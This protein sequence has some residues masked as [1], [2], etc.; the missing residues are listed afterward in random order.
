MSTA[1]PPD[2]E[3][4]ECALS[5]IECEESFAEFVKQAWPIIEPGTQLKWGWAM[6]AICSHLEAV[7]DGRI[8]RLLMNVPPGT[9]KSTLVGVMWP[10]WEWTQNPN[11]RYISTAHKADLAT[12]DNMKCR[13]L[14]QSEWYQARWPIVLVSD[15]NAKTKFENDSTGFRESMAFTSMTG[16]RG[17]RVILDDPLSADD[18]N[19]EAALLSAEL[20]FTETLPTRVNN[21]KSAIVVIMQRLHDKDTSGLILDRKL[22]YVHLRLPMR[23]EADNICE[24]EIGFKDPRTEEGE[25]LFEER[26]SEKQV[27]DLEKTMGSYA[28]AGQLQQRPTPRSGGLFNREWFQPL[29]ELPLGCQFVR[30]WDLAASTKKDSPYTAGVKIGKAPDGRLIIADCVRDKMTA[31]GVR[32]VIKATTIS[33]KCRVSIPQ[34]PG[35]AGKAQKV[36]FAE[37][38]EGFDCRFSPESGDKVTRALP[39]SAQ[40][41]AGNVY[42]LEGEWNKDFIDECAMFPNGKYKDQVDALSRAYSELMKMLS[43]GTGSVSTFAP[44]LGNTN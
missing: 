8:L 27:A 38:L 41:E 13:R 19:S 17:D 5:K 7:T 34:D 25:L 36:A 30:G 9:S 44:K 42:Y 33:D 37:L 18:A 6:D 21:E 12:R 39:I 32:T 4:I 23:F 26:F 15:Q 40:A 1:I 14:I 31:N 11:L 35:Q 3:E 16:S 28:A 2:L 10:A 29:K 43:L 24:T 22:P 20:A